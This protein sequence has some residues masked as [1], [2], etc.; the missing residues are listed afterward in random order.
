MVLVFFSLFLC[1]L[2]DGG[3]IFQFL[4]VFTSGFF[5]RFPGYFF[6][7]TIA[8]FGIGF[9]SFTSSFFSCIW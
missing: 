7:Y 6:V 9:F 1:L 4:S 3:A 5:S 2:V 8:F